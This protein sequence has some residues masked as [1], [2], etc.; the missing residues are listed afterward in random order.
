MCDCLFLWLPSKKLNFT[1]NISTEKNTT[2]ALVIKLKSLDSVCFPFYLARELTVTLLIGPEVLLYSRLPP[3]LLDLEWEASPSDMA[4][5]FHLFYWFP[6]MD[7]VLHENSRIFL[8]LWS[9]AFLV[10]LQIFRQAR[11]IEKLNPRDLALLC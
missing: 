4:W 7:S 3:F 10:F 8:I 2:P 11:Q 6:N 1:D 9:N 5:K